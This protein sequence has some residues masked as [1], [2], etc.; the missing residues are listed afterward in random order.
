MHSTGNI[1]NN[2]LITSYGDR[3]DL[4]CWSIPNRYKHQ[5]TVLYTWSWYNIV[6]QL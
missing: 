5:I 3:L 4:P 6:C 2:I 1:V